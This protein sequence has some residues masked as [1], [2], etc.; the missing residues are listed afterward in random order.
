MWDGGLNSP[1]TG[2]VLMGV[3]AATVVVL[4]LQAVRYFRG[5]RGDDDDPFGPRRE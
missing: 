2:I 5:R 3:A 4:V 1:F